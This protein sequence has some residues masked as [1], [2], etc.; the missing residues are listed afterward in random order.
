MF[1]PPLVQLP[2]FFAITMMLRELSQSPTPFDSESFFSLTTL[3]H[4]DP[5]MTL[6]ILLG[7]IT[8]ANVETNNWLMTAT[9]RANLKKVEDKRAQMV[10]DGKRIL[11]PGKIIKNALRGLSVIRI[12]IASVMPGV[13][14]IS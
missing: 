11:E 2:P 10:A 4:P 1:I 9:Q 5:T 14:G 8:M 3:A 6:P 7:A 13:G 12:L